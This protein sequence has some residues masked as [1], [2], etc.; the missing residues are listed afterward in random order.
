MSKKSDSLPPESLPLAKSTTGCLSDADAGSALAGAANRAPAAVL[1]QCLIS[2]GSNLGNRHELIAEAAH[3]VAS[4]PL[5]CRHLGKSLATS[6]LFE[7]P[8]IGG[9]GGQEPFLNAVAAFETEGSARDVLIMLQQVEDQLGRRRRRRWD[10]RTI[11]LDVVLHGQLVGGSHALTVPHPRYT[12]RQFVLQPACDVAGNYRD[13]RFGWTL[14]RLANHLSAAT[15]SLALVGSDLATRQAICERLSREHDIRTFAAASSLPTIPVIGNAPLPSRRVIGSVSDEQ[16]EPV[17]DTDG[18]PWVAAYLPPLPLLF[19]AAEAELVAVSSQP[20]VP[21]LVVR[22]QRAS[23]TTSP[24]VATRLAA[25][26]ARQRDDHDNSVGSAW[27][28]PHQI[29]PAGWTWPEYRLEIDDIDWAVGE[30]ASAIDSM[31]CPVEAV[32]QDGK[33]W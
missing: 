24:Q 16:H 32:T 23:A 26:L 10:A 9:P 20:T 25:N 27:P 29:W 18:Q 5:V 11:D 17:V 22:M 2:F 14:Q 33:W 6:R 31:R 28:A 30:L 13:P 19:G 4:S 21:R 8:P 3:R 7:T 1:S 12:A 15:P